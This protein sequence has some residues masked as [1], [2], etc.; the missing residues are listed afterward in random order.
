MGSCNHVVAVFHHLHFDVLRL[1]VVDEVGNIR[2][3]WHKVEAVLTC[4]SKQL[5][6]AASK[7]IF[8]GSSSRTLV[9]IAPMGHFAID[10]DLRL[11]VQR[12]VSHH[13]IYSMQH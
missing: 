5:E 7:G 4:A 10:Y 8:R 12:S 6:H 11:V 3:C 9:R 1:Q 13:N 2:P